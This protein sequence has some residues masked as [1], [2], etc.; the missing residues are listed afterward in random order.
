M[1]AAG[2]MQFGFGLS[3]FFI[4]TPAGVA[5]AIGTRLRLWTGEWFLDGSAGT[6]WLTQVLGTGTKPLYDTAIRTRILGTPGVLG[7]VSY[8]SSLDPTT[9]A[10]TVSA[11][12]NTVYGSDVTITVASSAVVPA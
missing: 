8:S 11:T 6:P 3:D 5:Q 7:I 12:V 2:D 1:T 9:R 10:L 4:D